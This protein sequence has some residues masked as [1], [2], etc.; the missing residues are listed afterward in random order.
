MRRFITVINDNKSNP[1]SYN[2]ITFI[3]A[4]KGRD[5]NIAGF[6]KNIM[7][8]DCNIIF[9]KQSDDN[10]FNKGALYNLAFKFCKTDI[11]IFADIDIRHIEKYNFSEL[12][13]K[14]NSP[15]VPFDCIRHVKDNMVIDSNFRLTAWGGCAV[16]TKK[17]FEECGGFSNRILHWGFDDELLNKRANMLRLKGSINHIHHERLDRFSKFEG[18]YEKNKEI[19]END[20]P[21]RDNL[22]TVSGEL[23]FKQIEDNITWVEYKNL[24]ND[25][26]FAPVKKQ[27]NIPNKKTKIGA[28]YTTFYDLDMIEKS[29]NS[30]R[31]VV[32][33]IVMVHQKVGFNGTTE[34]DFNNEII[35]RLIN[36]GLINDIIYFEGKDISTGMI[37][38]FNLG[39][40]YVKNNN[41]DFVITLAP[42]MRYN[43]SDI[44]SEI[45]NM[46][47]ENIETLYMPLKAYYYDEKHYFI[48]S[49]YYRAIYKVNNRIFE[50]TKSSVLCDPCAKM[51]EDNFKISEFYCHHYTFLKD[52]Y[53]NK[54]NNSIRCTAVYRHKVE[55]QQIYDR[56][57]NWK[58]GETALVFT[59]DM[60]LNGK[61]VLAEKEL[62]IKPLNKIAV[63]I[64][65][66]KRPIITNYT[67]SYY[68]E[69]KELLKDEM[70]LI[71]ICVGSEG[72]ISE[73]IA[74]KNNFNYLEYSNESIQLKHDAIY[75]EAK[76]YNPDACLKID[77][78][79][80]VSIEFF[81]YWNELID[82]GCDYSEVLDI[83]FMFKNCVGYWGGYE[84]KR[85]GEGTGVGRFTSKKLLDLMDW[86]IIGEDKPGILIDCFM[87]KRINQFDI[88][89]EKTTC[90]KLNGQI[91]ELKSDCQQTDL[92]NIKYSSI[93]STSMFKIVSDEIKNELAYNN[94]IE[95][96]F[97]SVIIPTMWVSEYIIKMLELYEENKL[98]K[99]IIIIDNAPGN[100]KDISKFT[101]VKILTKGENIYVNPAWNWGVSEAKYKYIIIANDD[102]LFN[103]NDLDSL[104]NNSKALLTPNMIIGAYDKCF[105]Q[106]GLDVSGLSIVPVNERN[107]G[108]GTFMIMK[109]NSYTFIPDDLLIWEGD[110]IQFVNNN[111]YNFKGIEIQTPMGTTIRAE[112]LRN[113]AKKDVERAS[114]YDF[115]KLKRNY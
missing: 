94:Y 95:Y 55:M 1:E 60:K 15:F 42:D 37:E 20:N 2:G 39:L 13:Q 11:V 80:I 53:S 99:E 10:P 3:V 68:L 78:D 31:L 86:K 25:T 62:E 58:E 30:L 47:E 54:L 107:W 113:I 51:R 7:M 46:T 90:K 83:Y 12:M 32:D 16:F 17:Q 71:L 87:T 52:K 76:K 48:D 45:I 35:E 93:H 36:K 27:I 40:E 111:A 66:W 92:K 102:I 82:N 96:D 6:V 61:V 109:R 101:K 63:L 105:K 69:L 100:K 110:N 49:Y 64:P 23:V 24:G 9:V 8:Y 91:I 106:K 85:N 115:K 114:K 21:D 81:R 50:R 22:N 108:F 38:K 28:I 73:S 112:G 65:M 5:Y 19:F 89:R 41:C 67:F 74:L 14:Y 70:E 29:I 18:Y 72:E 98:I 75:T 34:P 44:K 59:N 43:A 56:L 79:S 84:G 57:L 97:F 88:I 77:S 26:V 103:K 33:Y 4:I 104:I